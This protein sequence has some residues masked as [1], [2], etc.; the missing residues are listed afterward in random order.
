MPVMVE[1]NPRSRR[2]VLRTSAA[3]LALGTAGVVASSTAT[4]QNGDEIMVNQSV[5]SPSQFYYTGFS[6][7]SMQPGVEVVSSEA[8][9][10]GGDNDLQLGNV[11][12]VK[13][14]N[15]GPDRINMNVE[16]SDGTTTQVVEEVDV[17]SSFI[18]FP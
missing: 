5:T 16:L 13:W 17:R 11:G 18:V 8:I 2:K 1:D 15:P 6:A 3:A 4:A 7:E 9:P 14:D 10:E 12:F